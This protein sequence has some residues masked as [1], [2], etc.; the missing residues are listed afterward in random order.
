M[1]LLAIYVCAAQI[2]GA[3]AWELQEP[4]SCKFQSVACAMFSNQLVLCTH[5]FLHF[6][7]NLEVGAQRD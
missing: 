6:D 7:V 5:G 1:F 3:A 4:L 2:E